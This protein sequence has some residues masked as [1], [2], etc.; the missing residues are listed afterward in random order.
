ME[1]KALSNYEMQKVLKD[2]PNLISY[3]MLANYNNILDAMN[4]DML[5]LLYE[6]DQLFGHWCCLFLRST[7]DP[8]IMSKN[9]LSGSHKNKK[10]R[11][12]SRKL[13]LEY[14]NSY[15]RMPDDEL[16]HIPDYFRRISGQDFPHL[17][18]LLN[19]LG[20]ERK[21]I[22]LVYNN[23]ILQKSKPDINTCGRWVLCRLLMKSIPI[24]EFARIFQ[25]NEFYNSDDL[26]SLLTSFIDVISD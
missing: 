11:K 13:E 18:Y 8:V 3:G 19:K 26:V 1:E 9:I 21:D 6:T 17:S 15:G 22:K 20:K 12:N 5:I 23:H 24:D 4:N 10:S 7:L 25:K 2:K 16:A 14:F